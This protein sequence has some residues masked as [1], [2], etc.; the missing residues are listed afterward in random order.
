MYEECVTLNRQ[1]IGSAGSNVG[2]IEF[3]CDLSK[4]LYQ[5]SEATKC[6][7]YFY[8]HKA[9]SAGLGISQDLFTLLCVWR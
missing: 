5:S 3:V 1:S 8:V 9:E 6:I 4:V 2:P 7:Q